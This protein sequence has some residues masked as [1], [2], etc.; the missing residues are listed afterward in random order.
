MIKCDPYEIER[1]IIN[2]VGNAVKFTPEGGSITID[3]E[4][5]DDKVKISVTDTGCGIDEKF[6]KAIFDRFS[7]VE[8]SEPV[9]S[10]SGLGLT[11]TN[12]IIKLHKG[13]I[14]VE[15]ELGKGSTFVIIL[16]VNPEV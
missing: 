11:I 6:H 7:Q 14:Y 9:K 15:S 12:Q 3:I 8:D 1:C 10:G 2:L 4:D 16:P 13:K 5:L